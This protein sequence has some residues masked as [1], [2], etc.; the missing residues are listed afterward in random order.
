MMAGPDKRQRTETRR[1]NPRRLWLHS[2]FRGLGMRTCPPMWPQGR[3]RTR[4]H[5]AQHHLS[6]Q[7]PFNPPIRFGAA[8]WIQ[9]SPAA[10][11]DCR[12]LGEL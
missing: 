5:F 4:L 6:P 10:W 2:V 1:S 12:M 9:G 3:S 7:S 11:I 8:P